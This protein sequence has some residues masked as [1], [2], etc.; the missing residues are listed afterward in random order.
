MRY[1]RN[2]GSA[3]E[4]LDRLADFIDMPLV[5]WVCDIAQPFGCTNADRLVCGGRFPEDTAEANTI[6]QTLLP[7]SV[8]TRSR[9]TTLPFV[10]D[11]A[12][13]RNHRRGQTGM[14]RDRSLGVVSQRF[15]LRSL[16]SIPVH[17][18]KGQ[19]SI[20]TW[21]GEQPVHQAN[22][23]VAE[24]SIELLAIAHFVASIFYFST[25]DTEDAEQAVRLT[26]RE[27]DCLRFMAQ[28]FRDADIARLMKIA[29]TTVRYHI[30]NA[31]Q[32]LGASNRTHAAAVAAQS[33]LLGPIGL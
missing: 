26:P 6:L 3:F 5:V 10:T 30:D 23:L 19:V 21:A 7:V 24:A 20:L 29:L 15:E 22:T 1:C 32:K 8:Q 18:P 11:P 33:G 12:R 2:R 27:W 4:T 25:P 16:V 28:G 13:A 14:R 31:V 9:L 17:L